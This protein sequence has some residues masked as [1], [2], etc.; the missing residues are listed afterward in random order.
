MSRSDRVIELAK[1]IDKYRNAYYNENI[2]LVSDEEYDKL[3]DELDE[4]TKKYQD[5][6]IDAV[7]FLAARKAIDRVGYEVVTE[8]PTVKH[9]HPL[10]SLDKTKLPEDIVKFAN[11]QPVLIM[12]KMDGLTCTL[13]YIDGKLE[14]AI[15]RG[16][17]EEGELITHNA[18]VM[19]SIPN[20]ID[21]V[22]HEIIVDG[23]L[24]VTYQD[25]NRVNQE[26][27]DAGVPE[28]EL[29]AN[30][31]SMAAGTARQLDSS[32]CVHRN[33]KFVAWKC[34]KGPDT[35]AFNIRLKWLE[36]MGFETVEWIYENNLDVKSFERYVKIIEL[37][38][39]DNDYKI[40][41]CVVGYNSIAYGDSLGLTS[42]HPRNQLAFKFYDEKYPTI[43]RDVKWTLGKTGTITPTA[44]FD[45]VEID[46]TTVCQA[47]MHNIT[48]MKE[49]R[50]QIGAT[51]HVFKANMIIP[52]IE[53]FDSE[54][55][56]IDIPR[57]CPEC[58]AETVVTMDNKTEVL[59]C[60][61]PRC[62]GQQLKKLEAFVSKSGMDIDGFG[63][64]TLEL[65]YDKGW[66][67]C[68]RDIYTLERDYGE[69]IPF[70]PGWSNKSATKLFESIEKSRN[71]RLDK[72]I[73]ALSITNIS[74][75]TAKVICEYFD[76]D[77]RTFFENLRFSTEE[78]AADWAMIPGIGEK[79]AKDIHKWYQENNYD[80]WAFIDY[81]N[82]IK[83]EKKL[84]TKS[85]PALCERTFCITG[86]F[87]ESRDVLKSKIEELGGIFVSGVSKNT[88]I[89][90]VGDKAGSKLDKAKKLGVTIYNE[91]DLM[92]ILNEADS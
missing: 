84:N 48:I 88:D 56:N 9:N 50:A 4:L 12:P 73:S 45:A 1:L 42:H 81:I 82:F 57:Y 24:M 34:Y 18:R 62:K 70:L 29:F 49:L 32:V 27:L 74:S 77:D 52:Q 2:S 75:G 68:F 17:G 51:C 46:G 47:S 58:G 76:Y 71:V 28:N 39:K 35:D 78:V 83:P 21:T 72:F 37:W 7:D 11:D 86:T 41:G 22:T 80:L 19:K 64:A 14:S 33:L 13:R 53:S 90:F 67:R 61:N 25:F 79:T 6:F 3:Y 5:E 92:R 89:L 63:G 16:N 59:K 20:E 43:L 66:V 15:T 60:I 85:S 91:E 44:I 10:L 26:L 69:R 38:A 23:E 40:D 36:R 87:S 30:P 55:F 54:Y 31:R 8:L 65:F